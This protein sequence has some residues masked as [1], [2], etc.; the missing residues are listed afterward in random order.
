[1]HDRN[2]QN[3]RTTL[4]AGGRWRPRY[5]SVIASTAGRAGRAWLTINRRL[6]HLLACSMCPRR[7]RAGMSTSVC[8]SE[9]QDSASDTWISLM[10][11]PH[12]MSSSIGFAL[13]HLASP[14]GAG[15]TLPVA[16]GELTPRLDGVRRLLLANCSQHTHRH[17]RALS[18]HASW[19]QTSQA[20]QPTHRGQHAWAG[21]QGEQNA[22]VGPYCLKAK[23]VPAWTQHCVTTEIGGTHMG[24]R[25]AAI[26][27]VG[28]LRCHRSLLCGHETA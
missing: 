13:H 12:K 20:K 3:D 11:V 7:G 24:R 15:E 28:E 14:L 2:C 1:M 10:H 23:K 27:A 9:Q 19:K 6:L 26:L 16:A 4:Q 8:I 22:E 17:K 25:G 5:P 18:S 21:S